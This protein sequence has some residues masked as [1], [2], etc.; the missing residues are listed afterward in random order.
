MTNAQYAAMKLAFQH[1]EKPEDVAAH[2]KVFSGDILTSG[3]CRALIVACWRSS[4][5]EEADLKE[6]A[7]HFF[8]RYDFNDKVKIDGMN[9]VLF[10]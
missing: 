10:N 9:R 8:N 1:L 6:L 7:E 3:D 5:S 2:R 4:V